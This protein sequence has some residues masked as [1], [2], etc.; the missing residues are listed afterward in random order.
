MPAAYKNMQECMLC[1]KHRSNEV[2][3]AWL[4]SL[5][6]TCTVINQS[7]NVSR[8]FMHLLIWTSETFTGKIRRILVSIRSF[9]TSDRGAPYHEMFTRQ[10]NHTWRSNLLLNSAFCVCFVLFYTVYSTVFFGHKGHYLKIVPLISRCW[11]HA[12]LMWTGSYVGLERSIHNT[13]R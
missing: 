11:S 9:R 2:S 13:L 8:G 10:L 5:H 1:D 3:G 6:L 12:R 7:K 4:T